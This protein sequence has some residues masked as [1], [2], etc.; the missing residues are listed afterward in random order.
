MECGHS[1]ALHRHDRACAVGLKHKEFAMPRWLSR[2][3]RSP[4]AKFVCFRPSR[5][6]DRQKLLS[7]RT[8]SGLKSSADKGKDHKENVHYK[9]E[10]GHHS[11]SHLNDWSLLTIILDRLFFF[12]YLL[13]NFISTL[14]VIFNTVGSE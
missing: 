12:V 1:G 4:L 2:C 9:D 7:F 8:K 13:I 6:G 3:V 10:D 14:Y 5:P 11:D